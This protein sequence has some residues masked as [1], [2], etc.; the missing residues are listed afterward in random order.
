MDYTPVK[1]MRYKANGNHHRGVALPPPP[2]D[3][4][5]VIITASREVDENKER[6]NWSSGLEFLLSCLSYAVGLG[7][8]WRFPYLCY[9][10]GGGAFLIPYTI[11]LLFVGLPLFLMELSFGQYASEGP[12]TI[13]KISPLFQGIGYAMFLMTTLVGIY[14][15]MILAWALFY[16]GSSLTTQLPWSSCS[17]WWNTDACRRF[18]TKNCTSHGGVHLANGTCILQ[19][20][21]DPAVW[22]AVKNST[23]RKSVV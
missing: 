16:L 3:I 10:N 2:P 13:W 15:N 4:P 19:E 9:R 5:E 21:V 12:I 20:E 6:G 22:D 18:D 1:V 14:Y 17:N 23:D 8:I 11:M 7:N